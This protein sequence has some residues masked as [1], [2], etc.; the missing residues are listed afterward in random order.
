MPSDPKEDAIRHLRIVKNSKRVPS[1]KEIKSIMKSLN[2][3][4]VFYFLSTELKFEMVK[5]MIWRTVENDQI[6]IENASKL[7]KI[8]VV[9]QGKI[10]IFCIDNGIKEIESVRQDGDIIGDFEFFNPDKVSHYTALTKKQ[11]YV[12]ELMR[13]DFWEVIMEQNIKNKIDA[14]NELSTHNDARSFSI[15][16]SSNILHVPEFK[17]I[18]LKVNRFSENTKDFDMHHTNF[19]YVTRAHHL[20]KS[21][22]LFTNVFS[23]DLMR[24][25]TLATFDFFKKEQTILKQ[26]NE[27]VEN[28]NFYIIETGYVDLFIN[29][30]YFK[31]LKRGE[32]FG[33]LSFLDEVVNYW[34]V[35][36]TNTSCIR[37]SRDVFEYALEPLHQYIFDYPFAT[38]SE[39]NPSI[40]KSQ[41]GQCI[42]NKSMLTFDAKSNAGSLSFLDNESYMKHQTYI[43]ELNHDMFFVIQIHLLNGAKHKILD[44]NLSL[45]DF[46][47]PIYFG[48]NFDYNINIVLN[49][50]LHSCQLEDIYLCEIFKKTYILK[51]FKKIDVKSFNEK[52]LDTVKQSLSVTGHF[53]M[54]CY[55]YFQD[56]KHVYVI[57]ERKKTNSTEY[58]KEV[59]QLTREEDCANEST[60]LKSLCCLHFCVIPSH[61]SSNV[62]YE[63]YVVF[64]GACVLL[65]LE[66]LHACH[67]VY[68]CL[69]P[70]NILID[71]HGYAYLSQYY[72]IKKINNQR[73]QTLCGTPGFMAPEILKGEEYDYSVDFWAFGVTLYYLMYG[74]N[75]YENPDTCGDYREVMNRSCDPNFK[76]SF[77]PKTCPL[78]KSLIVSLLTVDKTRRLCELNTI[79]SHPVFSRLDWNALKEKKYNLLIKPNY[80]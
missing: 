25:L 21:T 44:Y 54:R 22:S 38:K 3:I 65:S 71:D 67:I 57:C 7:N 68:R 2:S 41:P 37:F 80:D 28:P 20:L 31:R 61:S 55:A 6:L 47:N 24:I 45:M 15:E 13:N 75:P 14:G 10:E 66:Y 73:T 42:E 43:Q 40:D 62:T 4:A 30:S 60:K 23:D 58:L 63:F 9:Q 34:I 51:S 39:D 16:F 27:M 8:F 33:D 18:R 46:F 29:N 56:T 76:I 11:T 17:M 36:Q 72:F 35:A 59:A 78:F 70:Q 69:K 48:E 79:K 52:L 5:K 49:K 32:Y 50:Q 74:T 12:W 77:P 64:I 19:S 53:C 26:E 1:S